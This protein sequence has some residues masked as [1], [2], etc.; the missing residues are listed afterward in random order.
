MQKNNS[1]L[2]TTMPVGKAVAKLAI[3]PLSARLLSSCIAWQTPSLS[4]RLVTPIS[5]R[6]CLLHSRFSHY[7]P[8]LLTCLA[9][10]QIASLQEV[11]VKAM[12][13]LQKK[14]LL[15][16]FGQALQ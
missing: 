1:E 3:P 7:L 5:W 12:R 14:R 8:L 2:F 4:D 16:D 15:L 10:V 9:L 6:L 13:I 11:W